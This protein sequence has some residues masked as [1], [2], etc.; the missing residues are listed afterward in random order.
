MARP[1]STGVRAPWQARASADACAGEPRGGEA[2]QHR[3]AG[4]LAGAAVPVGVRGVPGGLGRVQQQAEVGQPARRLVERRPVP[5]GQRRRVLGEH[6]REIAAH[7]LGQAVQPLLHQFGR[8]EPGHVVQREQVVRTVTSHTPRRRERAP[9]RPVQVAPRGQ[10]PRAGG[11]VVF[12]PAQ[13]LLGGAQVTDVGG[14]PGELGGAGVVPGGAPG[15]LAA[16]GHRVPDLPP[17]PG[18][19][20]PAGAELGHPG[21]LPARVILG[22]A[23]TRTRDEPREISRV[24]ACRQLR[25]LRG[26]G[27]RHIPRRPGR[28]GEPP[29]AQAADTGAQS[30]AEQGVGQPHP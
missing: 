19:P 16:P 17:Q 13:R 9:Q 22:E 28:T 1:V 27:T 29:C 15:P 3:G 14:G 18:E 7:R 21:L 20:R 10:D 8:A 24:A 12:A 6:G 11:R 26:K 30:G 25:D 2:G 5:C 4:P 23:F